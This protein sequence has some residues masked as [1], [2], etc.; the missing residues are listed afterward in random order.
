MTLKWVNDTSAK[1]VVNGK[2]CFKMNFIEIGM[3]SYW[4]VVRGQTDGCLNLA[5]QRTGMDI[6]NLL[7]FQVFAVDLNHAWN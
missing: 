5:G 7:C 1:Y 2:E 6:L 4:V 3:S